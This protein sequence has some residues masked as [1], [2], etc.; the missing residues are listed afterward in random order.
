MTSAEQALAAAYRADWGRLLALLLTRSRR[1]DLVE[2]ALAE[3]FAR[4][5]ARWPEAGVPA[6]PSGWLYA[7][8]H[9][10][11]IDALRAEEVAARKAALVA[12]RP[13]STSRPGPP[14]G[15]P[16]DRLDLILLCRHPALPLPARS[17]LSLRLVMGTPRSR[18]P[19]CSSCRPRR[20]RRG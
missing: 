14:D 3:A 6:N 2:D 1:L 9:R 16:D 10:Q 19:G 15:L 7:V 11:I 17:A 12:I 18:S 20:W 4:G 13:E 5:A 8:A